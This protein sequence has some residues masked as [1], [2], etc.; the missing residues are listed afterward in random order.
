MIDHTTACNNSASLGHASLAPFQLLRSQTDCVSANSPRALV[1]G[2][3]SLPHQRQCDVALI[4]MADS[5]VVVDRFPE[6]RSEISQGFDWDFL[7]DLNDGFGITCPDSVTQIKCTTVSAGRTFTLDSDTGNPPWVPDNM[8][9]AYT[10][11]AGLCNTNKVH[12]GI[13]RSDIHPGQRHWQPFL[14]T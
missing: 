1:Q 13:S 6:T 3:T 10:A 9:K 12:Y 4:A 5:A 14:G 7:P 2:L 8:H 11:L